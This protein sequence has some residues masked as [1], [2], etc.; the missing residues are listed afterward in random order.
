MSGAKIV[1]SDILLALQAN[2]L[3]WVDGEHESSSS[4]QPSRHRLQSIDG[5][6]KFEYD[7]GS[8]YLAPRGK[9]VLS[10]LTRASINV[11]IASHER[12]RFFT[13]E[14]LKKVLKFA[15]RKLA[16]AMKISMYFVLLSAAV[17]QAL[18]GANACQIPK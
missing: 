2:N 11:D 13:A 3:G 4:S 16:V 5:A 15:N 10:T 12:G 18:T 8:E 1:S 6:M 9:L 7:A 17:K 14:K